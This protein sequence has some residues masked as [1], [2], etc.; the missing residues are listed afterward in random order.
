MHVISTN[1]FSFRE[2]IPNGDIVFNNIVQ[3]SARVICCN[4]SL[5]LSIALLNAESIKFSFKHFVVDK[6]KAY[7]KL[8]AR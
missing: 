6:I 8:V 1:A 7:G 2:N 5:S 3:K 4:D